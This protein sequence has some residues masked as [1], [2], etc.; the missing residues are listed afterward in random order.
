MEL[1]AVQTSTLYAGR[2]SLPSSNR[3]L[4]EEECAR[5]QP[6]TRTPVKIVFHRV[7]QRGT[8]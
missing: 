4:G 6:V 8:W 1:V 2:T 5:A 3:L 7:A